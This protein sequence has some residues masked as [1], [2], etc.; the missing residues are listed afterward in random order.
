MRHQMNCSNCIPVALQIWKP[1]L[2]E[3]AEKGLYDSGQ[4]LILRAAAFAALLFPTVLLTSL[5]VPLIPLASLLFCYHEKTRISS[6]LDKIAV[7]RFKENIVVDRNVTNYLSSHPKALKRLIG[8]EVN[9]VDEYNSS[10]LQMIISVLEI[11]NIS[12]SRITEILTIVSD[13]RF[14]DKT[15]VEALQSLFYRLATNSIPAY[16]VPA[17]AALFEH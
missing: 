4:S 3:R 16:A 8:Q 2:S 12:T 5:A 6:K 17:Y 9:K 1:A 7:E 15:K 13:L 10:L 14:N 11:S